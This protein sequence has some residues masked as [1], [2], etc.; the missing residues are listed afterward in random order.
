MAILLKESS[1]NRI[2]GNTTA[3]FQLQEDKHSGFI[4]AVDNNQTRLALEYAVYLV[5]ELNNE[6]FYLRQDVEELKKQMAG[7]TPKKRAATAKAKAKAGAS[8][9]SSPEESPDEN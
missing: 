9:E 2:G 6:V 4:T 8:E 3:A 7:K 5:T 1:R